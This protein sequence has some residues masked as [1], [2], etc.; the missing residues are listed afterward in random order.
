MTKITK[1]P[2]E[3]R[4]LFKKLGFPLKTL[5]DLLLRVTTNVATLWKFGGL[6]LCRLDNGMNFTYSC[7]LLTERLT[8][9]RKY[10]RVIHMT[11]SY[12]LND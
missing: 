1:L 6:Y 2:P 3:A 10:S 11:S 4:E 8:K 5:Q 12:A 9:Y 7:K